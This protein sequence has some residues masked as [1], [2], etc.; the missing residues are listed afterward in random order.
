MELGNRTSDL[1]RISNIL[2]IKIQIVVISQ[3][4]NT[5]YD[6]EIAFEE[7]NN[8]KHSWLKTNRTIMSFQINTQQGN[9][10]FSIMPEPISWPSLTT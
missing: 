5:F 3:I 2:V 6:D 8:I 1:P 4:K 9:Q 10:K 7:T